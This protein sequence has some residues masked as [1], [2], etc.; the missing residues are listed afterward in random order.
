MVR[1]ER[2]APDKRC[3]YLRV[4]NPGDGSRTG[5]IG[6]GFKLNEEV[7]LPGTGLRIKVSG[8]GIVGD[9]WIIAARPSTPTE[10]VPWTLRSGE[11]PHGPRR[12]YAPLAMLHWT[13]ST[14]FGRGVTVDS[15][16]R[17]FQPLTRRKGCCTVTV[18][19]ENKSFGDFTSITAALASIPVD[20]PAKICV[21]PGEYRERV[22][23]HGR[24]HLV[25][26]GCGATTILRTPTTGPTTAGLIAISSSHD[27]VLKDL[28]IE[29]TG[30]FGVEIADP[31]LIAAPPP[32]QRRIR[33]EG[34][35]IKTTRDGTLTPP[36]LT[37]LW[38]P[39][40]GA[41]PFPMSTI[42]ALRVDDL[43]ITGCVTSMV[44]DLSGAPNIS[45]YGCT[46][47]TIRGNRIQTIDNATAKRLA[48]GGIQIGADC[49]R[50]LVEDN[51]IEGG[52][53]YGITFGTGQTLAVGQVELDVFDPIG[54][55]AL[56]AA[57][58]L[59]NSKASLPLSAL[60]AGGATSVI[61][62]YRA[63]CRDVRILRNTI[64]GMGSSGISVLGFE[65][66]G[67]VGSSTSRWRRTTSRS[68]TTSS[69]AIVRTAWMGLR[70]AIT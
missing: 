60:P 61:V 29:A 13:F 65:K 49:E 25:I 45:L 12:F 17:T 59:Y 58:T 48:W 53:G 14:A 47:A 32:F 26:E 33:L 50:V 54:R 35:S 36:G 66:A 22:V 34:L 24:S 4:W 6:L 67:L 7:A 37:N 68:P 31:M 9:H 64:T 27:I 11:P 62:G 16:R 20:Q 44:G 40:S 41:A 21:L 2:R 56:V 19:D 28:T 46:A 8:P 70:R 15:C 10:V 42:A 18:G 55:F 38:I 1:A 23:I 3:F 57:G 43:R 30:Q 39:L 69:A 52:S 51:W 5:P 63:D